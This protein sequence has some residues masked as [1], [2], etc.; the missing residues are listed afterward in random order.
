MYQI[1]WIDVLNSVFF[2]YACILFAMYLFNAI[3]SI[4]ELRSYSNKNEYVNYK[5]MLAFEKLPTI[6]IIAPAYN[7]EKTI[8]ENIKCLI[9]L[10]YQNFEIIIVNDGSND[11]TLLK[12][13]EHFDLVKVS[14][15][16]KLE[17]DCAPIKSIYQSKNPA[18]NHL[19]LIDKE[20]GGKADAL[21]A[22]INVSQNDLFLAIDVDCILESDALLKMVKPFIDNNKHVVIASGGV[23]RIANS[24]EV[25]NGRISKVNYPKN[26]WAKFQ[27]LEYFRAFT[28]GRMAWSKLNGLLIISGAFGLFDKKRV[29]R[30]GGYDKNSIGEDLELVVRLRRYMHEVEKRKYR[31]AFIP[32]PLCWTEV[33]ESYKVLSRQRNRWT[34][35]AIDTILKHKKM[36]LNPK[37]GRVGMI[38]FPYWVVF[39][40]LAPLIQII[41]LIYLFLTVIFGL[42][43]LHVFITLLLFVFSFSVMYSLFAIFF[44]AYTYH[45]YKGVSYMSQAVLFIFLE[46]FIYQPLNM[47]FSLSGHFDFYFKKNK[48]NWGEMT[49]TGFTK[50]K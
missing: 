7:E 1:Q 31:V 38:S 5:S 24:S 42:L 16:F 40:W 30:V 21:N 20:N 9:S 22:G 28:L 14:R 4:L 32:D 50:E 36:F 15:A 41:G 47:V 33:P 44:E 13:I 48:K 6:S 45:K 8:I 49:R 11:N 26:F 34:R 37:Y 18:Y 35:G 17:L 12:V 19:V 27:V 10:Q 2:A 39:E 23:V 43:N 46:M 25:T 29:I 3:L